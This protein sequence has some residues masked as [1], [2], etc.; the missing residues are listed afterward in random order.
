MSCDG[1]SESAG[2]GYGKQPF[3]SI[4]FGGNF[5]NKICFVNKNVLIFECYQLNKQGLRMTIRLTSQI[6]CCFFEK[7]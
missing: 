6:F 4:D 1:F 3:V 2:S 7:F 5:G